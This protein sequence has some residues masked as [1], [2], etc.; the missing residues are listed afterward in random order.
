MSVTPRMKPLEQIVFPK[1]TEIVEHNSINGLRLE[2]ARQRTNKNKHRQKQIQVNYQR[3]KHCESLRKISEEKYRYQ[4]IMSIAK[5]KF[6]SFGAY[7]V[8]LKKEHGKIRK[9]I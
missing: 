9:D 7:C 1:G 3:N 8:K 6:A 2:S 5:K 4:N